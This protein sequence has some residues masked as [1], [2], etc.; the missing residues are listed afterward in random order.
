MKDYY[1][2]LGV[3]AG[4]SQP[5]LKKKYR[6]LARE[7][8]PDKSQKE[9]DDGRFK[10]VSEAYS[11]LGDEAKRA[12]YDEL[13]AAERARFSA[14]KDQG[15]GFSPRGGG[16]D[17]L[18]ASGSWN[19]RGAVRG[20]DYETTASVSFLEALDG[21]EIS[22]SLSEN[23]ECDACSGS[24][25]FARQVCLECRG[26]GSML[27]ERAVRARIPAGIVSGTKVVLRGK[28][29]SGGEGG[30][31]GDLF[32]EVQVAEDPVFSISGKNVLMNAGVPFEKLALGGE[33]RLTMPRGES[34]TV[35]LKPG[36]KNGANLRVA[37]KGISHLG[38][39]FGD[40]IVR[41]EVA[42][43]PVLSEGAKAALRAYEAEVSEQGE[44]KR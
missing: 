24:G 36:T 27:V 3:E 41:V 44:G 4:V 12:E 30:A 6:K 35:R 25:G 43:P 42:V 31:A 7:L 26:S 38:G 9:G 2:I 29:G 19:F 10:E 17:D 37:G 34:V 13:R 15:F 1:K 23:V 5:E 28:G 14:P 18:F 39:G 8:H 16:L 33:A 20:V 22:F 40:V 11:V 21:K 32:I